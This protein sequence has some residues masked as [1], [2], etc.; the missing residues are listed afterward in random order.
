MPGPRRTAGGA[1][2]AIG[3]TVEVDMESSEYVDRTL[4]LVSD[5][6]ARMAA[7]AR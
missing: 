6:H 5:M 4:S 7:F 2:Q 3:S 1:G